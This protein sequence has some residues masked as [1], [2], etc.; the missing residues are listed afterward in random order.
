MTLV[1]ASS[2]RA[3]ASQHAKVQHGQRDEESATRDR[4][5]KQE[6]IGE[7]HLAV[8]RGLSGKDAVWW[9]ADE[10]GDAA[11]VCRE[12]DAEQHCPLQARGLRDVSRTCHGRVAGDVPLGA[13]VNAV[14]QGRVEDV[15]VGMRQ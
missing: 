7:P 14:C 5:R 11:A 10:R 3:V 2:R 1:S 6:P 15:S 8:Q 9:R 12:R 4:R 13:R